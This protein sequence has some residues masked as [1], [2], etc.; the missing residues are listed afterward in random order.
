MKRREGYKGY[1]IVARSHELREGGFSAELS[2]E[3][4]EAD[5]FMETEFYLPNTFPSQ[6]SA[7]EAAIKEGRQRID[8]GFERGQAVANG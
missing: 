8:A 5:G 4:H 3:E 7:L 1:V 6:E 2:V